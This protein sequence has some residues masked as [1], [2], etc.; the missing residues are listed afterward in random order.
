MRIFQSEMGRVVTLDE[1]RKVDYPKALSAEGLIEEEYPFEA[2]LHD[3]LSENGGALNEIFPKLTERQRKFA[4]LYLELG[5]ASQAAVQAGFKLG[6]A[7]AAKRQPAVQAYLA[8][9]N[10]AIQYH[11][12]EVVQF[13][14]GVMRGEITATKLQTQ[15]AYELGRRAGLWRN[16]SAMRNLIGGENHD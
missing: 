13:L 15:A 1:L 4:D 12:D 7:Q 14:T 11:E 10:K 16:H 6:Y 3:C 5:N 2:Y 8:E 9:R